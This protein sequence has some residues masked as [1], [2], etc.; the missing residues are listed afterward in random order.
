[1]FGLGS[2]NSMYDRKLGLKN[3]MVYARYSRGAAGFK[4]T[5]RFPKSTRKWGFG[6]GE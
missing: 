2:N 3:D 4:N 5:P 6:R 1:M